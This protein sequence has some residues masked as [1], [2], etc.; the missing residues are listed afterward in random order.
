MADIIEFKID[1][2]IAV[3]DR[4]IIG[5]SYNTSTGGKV[6]IG[7]ATPCFGTPQ[8][9]PYDSL[10]VGS[11]GSGGLTGSVIDPNGTFA[12]ATNPAYYCQPHIFVPNYMQLDSS[13]TFPCWEGYHPLIQVIAKERKKNAPK[14]G[15]APVV[16]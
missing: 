11:D 16:P 3:P 4:M 1:G 12:N 15:A 9:C 5:I 6:P 14:G 7:T 10:N 8:G 13:A 2:K